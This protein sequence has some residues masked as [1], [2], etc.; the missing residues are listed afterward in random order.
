MT[1]NEVLCRI[2]TDRFDVP[3]LK[4]LSSGYWDRVLAS[5]NSEG[6][7]PMVYWTLSRSEILNSLPEPVR[8]KLSAAYAVTWLQNDHLLNELRI[9]TEWCRAAAIPIVLLKGAC[10]AL[11]I[12][13]DI[14]LRPMGDMDV[15]VPAGRRA[16]VA[17]FAK[18]QGFAEA[19]PE[20]APGIDEMLSLHVRLQK[21]GPQPLTLEVHDGLVGGRV[22]TYGVPV[23]WFWNQT[24]ELAG[25]ARERFESV[26]MLTP[27][28]QLLYA[29]A[30]AMLQHGGRGAPLRWF[31]DMHLLI[32][33]YTENLD[34]DLLLTQAKTFEWTSALAAAV[35]HTQ[36]C[37]DT[38]VPELVQS[39]LRSVSDRHQVLVANLQAK[40]ATRFQEEGEKLSG[41]SSYGKTRVVLAMV[42]PAPSYMKWRYQ[43]NSRWSLPGAYLRRWSGIL[44]DGL[45][46]LNVLTRR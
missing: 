31:L 28:A 20:A 33:H 42:F 44:A 35:S 36:S 10:F 8:H 37:F 18:S 2:V 24:T 9:L 46:T 45:R 12:Y 17:E 43:L 41:M 34:W 13:P 32:T 14:G 30:H 22:F 27:S 21:P 23:D 6:L 16:Q 7:S 3:T 1:E 38:P 5:A 25:S 39:R 29:T 4:A 26:R 40:P 19:L 11:T 15:L